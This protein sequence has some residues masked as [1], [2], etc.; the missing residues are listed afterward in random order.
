[1]DFKQIIIK[2]EN[3]DVIFSLQNSTCA[4]DSKVFFELGE[5]L[6][7]TICEQKDDLY[8]DG[9]VFLKGQSDS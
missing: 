8:I 2:K 4:F 9:T 5:R 1:M 3:G 6:I 7:V